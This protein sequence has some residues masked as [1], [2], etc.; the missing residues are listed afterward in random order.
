VLEL[1]HIIN[2]VSARKVRVALHEKG[3]EAKESI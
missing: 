2:S 3:L 1:Y